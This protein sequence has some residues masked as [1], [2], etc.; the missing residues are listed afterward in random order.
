MKILQVGELKAQFEKV[1][2]SVKQGEEFI[3]SYGDKKENVAVII[4]YK[5][6]KEK[7]RIKL[8]L[9]SKKGSYKIKEDFKMTSEELLGI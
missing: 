4:P 8:G 5:E 3:I 6:Y 7:N 1:F 2:E 9:L